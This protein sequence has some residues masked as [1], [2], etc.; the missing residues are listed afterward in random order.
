MALLSRSM[1]NMKTRMKVTRDHLLLVDQALSEFLKREKAKEAL[2]RHAMKRNNELAIQLNYTHLGEYLRSILGEMYLHNPLLVVGKASAS[3]PFHEIVSLG[4]FDAI[5][6]RM[7]DLVFRT[8]DDQRSTQ[9]LIKKI[10]DKTGVKLNPQMLDDAVYYLE[11]RHLIVHNSSLIDVKFEKRYSEKSQ[12][13]K[14][15]NKLPMSQGLARK[16]LSAIEE[17]CS[18]IDSG[19]INGGHLKPF[20]GAM[21]AEADSLEL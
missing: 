19:L 16:A 1:M 20:A 17:L 6:S 2:A 21:S 7:V 15:G 11:I 8:L 9:A 14:A 3:L 13:I 10:L 12:Y 18:A 5:S 4:N